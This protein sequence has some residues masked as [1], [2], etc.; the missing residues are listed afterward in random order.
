MRACACLDCVKKIKQS[1][2]RSRS[3]CIYATYIIDALFILF[4]LLSEKGKKKVFYY[5]LAITQKQRSY[6]PIYNM[7][8]L[9]HH[10]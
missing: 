9:L 1:T 6:V 7:K 2:S 8:L 3:V 4:V 10:G 5:L